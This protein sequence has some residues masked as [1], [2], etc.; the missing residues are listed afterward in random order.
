ME[1]VSAAR[2]GNVDGGGIEGVWRRA[3]FF[4][5]DIVGWVT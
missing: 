4:G 3:K 2:R 1:G 5:L